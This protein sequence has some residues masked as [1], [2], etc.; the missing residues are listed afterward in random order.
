MPKKHNITDSHKTSLAKYQGYISSKSI[1]AVT[2]QMKSHVKENI[3]K[4]REV[5][6]SVIRSVLYCARQDIGL[7]GHNNVNKFSNEDEYDQ[8][9]TLITNKNQGNFKELLDLLCLENEV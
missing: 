7:R 1:G 2:T 3:Y 5:L 9:T 8:E 4:N 6:K